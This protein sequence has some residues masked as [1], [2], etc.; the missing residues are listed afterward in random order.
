VSAS[1]VVSFEKK[2]DQI[3]VPFLW[4][5]KLHQ[6]IN[7]FPLLIVAFNIEDFFAGLS[8]GWHATCCTH[9]SLLLFRSLCDLSLGYTLLAAAVP[10]QHASTGEG[11]K[12]KKEE[13]L[14]SSNQTSR[15]KSKRFLIKTEVLG[16]FN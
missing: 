3:Y 1:T 6:K 15:P 13:S 10:S 2:Y 11:Q 4:K 14:V 8:E 16:G 9:I 12:K 5:T 7:V